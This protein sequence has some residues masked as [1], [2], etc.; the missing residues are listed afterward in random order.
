MA[1]PAAAT[2]CGNRRVYSDVM[3][4]RLCSCI[5]PERTCKPGS[6]PLAGRRSFL[7]GSGCP[8][9]Q[10]AYPGLL[11]AR[12][13]PRPLFGLAPGGVCNA[14]DV[15]IRAVGSYPAISPLPRKRGGMLS[16]ALSLT[17]FTRPPGV[18]RHPALRSPDFP[19]TMCAT[20]QPVPDSTAL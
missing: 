11:A 8:Q 4:R 3:R 14:P 7:W 13:T 2:T 1:A 5:I 15:A 19:R 17:G 9:P 16:V 6:V 12:A 20:V 10:A 18:T